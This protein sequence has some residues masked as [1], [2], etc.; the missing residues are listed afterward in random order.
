VAQ[1]KLSRSGIPASFLI[2]PESS[3]QSKKKKS[4]N[5]KINNSKAGVIS[6][7]VYQ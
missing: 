1:P 4:K 2:V 5:R 6:S 3:A 7:A